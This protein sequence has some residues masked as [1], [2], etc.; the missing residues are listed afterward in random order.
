LI[1]SLVA[2]A[3]K[4]GARQARACK[5]LGLDR[6]TVQ[7]W[8]YGPLEDQRCGPRR[9][10][11][12]KMSV[13]ERRHLLE[14]A[15]RPEH[16][17]LPPSQIVPRLADN[18]EYVGS[19]STMY[20][21]LREAKQLKHR[22]RARPRT[23][24][25]PES[26]VAKGP[27]E[28]W[29]WDITYLKSPVRG[30]FFYLYL[31]LDVWSRKIVGFEVYDR[32]SPDLAAELVRRTCMVEG[33]DASALLVLHS[34]NGGPMK[35]ATMLATLDH[36]GVR[37]SFSRPRVSDDNPFSEALF[38]TL[39]YRPEYPETPFASIEHAREWVMRFV[40]WYN[41]DHRHSSIRF[42][43]PAQRHNGNDLVILAQRQQVYE[44]A[45]S[46]H[47]ERWTG[48]S[49]DWSPI[50]TVELNPSRVRRIKVEEEVA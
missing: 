20:R 22:G 44:R 33:I 42:V 38:R 40:R 13:R 15:N 23:S 19:E 26:Y 11:S 47:P 3:V 45:R 48:Q 14:V 30:M 8:K 28:I 34:D 39:K 2:E 9:S 27:R 35:G 29:S 12:N 7:R 16:R 31:I 37:A 18:G 6:R 24:R 49:R 10:P 43:T 25:R 4:R 50:T 41:E 21:A 36:L 46:K 32:E 1:L 17:D 5:T